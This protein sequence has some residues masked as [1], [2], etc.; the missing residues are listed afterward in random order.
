[1]VPPTSTVVLSFSVKPRMPTITWTFVSMVIQNLV[2]L[3][4]INSS[5]THL[6]QTAFVLCSLSSFSSTPNVTKLL[7]SPPHPMCPKLVVVLGA[8]LKTSNPSPD[9][10]GF[11]KFQNPVPQSQP[12]QGYSQA[13]MLVGQ[14]GK[15]ALSGKTACSCPTGR[16]GGLNSFTALG[17]V[18]EWGLGPSL[19]VAWNR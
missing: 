10:R 5:D 8:A 12:C 2:N 4:M 6:P 18:A 9:Q 13:G 11:Q 3:T 17:L 14:R 7:S 15:G 19:A 1:M 16:L